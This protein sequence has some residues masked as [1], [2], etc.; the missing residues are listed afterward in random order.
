MWA[1]FEVEGIGRARIRGQCLGMVRNPC[2][3]GLGWSCVWLS[4]YKVDS[5][6]SWR[7]A[8]AWQVAGSF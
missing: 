1:D 4:W 7:K 2:Y 8:C 6:R 5:S 3:N